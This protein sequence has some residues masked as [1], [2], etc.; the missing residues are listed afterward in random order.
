[1]DHTL[2]RFRDRLLTPLRTRI[3][4]VSNAAQKSRIP[5]W[6]WVALLALLL[7]VWAHTGSKAEGRMTWLGT[8]T[9]S[10]ESW[11]DLISRRGFAP[12]EDPNWREKAYAEMPESSRQSA[13]AYISEDRHTVALRASGD[14]LY[15]ELKNAPGK[16]V[17]GQVVSRELWEGLGVGWE[18]FSALEALELPKMRVPEST[19]KSAESWKDSR[20]IEY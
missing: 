12:I 2:F 4:C 18:A 7:S 1:M 11:K 8:H 14:W 19:Q 5:R 20:S 16:G 3:S 15:F 10:P 13:S 17:P 6:V 9:P